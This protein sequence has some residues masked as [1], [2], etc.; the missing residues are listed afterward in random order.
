MEDVDALVFTAEG[1]SAWTLV[2]PEYSVAVPQPDIFRLPLAYP[3]ARDDETFVRFL[4]SWVE[5][6]TKDRTVERLFGHWIL[7]QATRRKE[8]R[9]S[10]I[11]DVLGW[12]E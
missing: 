6:K 12:V 3:T 4:S 1:G 2:Y 7:G 8:P 9:W 11:R 5:L 10:V